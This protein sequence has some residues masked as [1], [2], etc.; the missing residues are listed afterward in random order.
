MEENH[1]DN[2]QVEGENKKQD[3]SSDDGCCQPKKKNTFSKMI[4]AVILL[5]A[6]AIIG[7]KLAGRSA[8]ASDKQ[9]LAAPGKA[10][11]CDTTKTKSC[12][13]TKVSSCC[14]KK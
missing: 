6:M 14:S 8:N 13:T 11:C 9:T 12:D 7:V 4:F 5:A 10:S 3:C 1:K 2:L